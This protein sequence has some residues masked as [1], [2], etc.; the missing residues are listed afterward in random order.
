MLQAGTLDRY[1]N[2][3]VTICPVIAYLN[4]QKGVLD[5]WQRSIDRVAPLFQRRGWQAAVLC[6]GGVLFVSG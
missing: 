5:K 4:I 1:F 6:K 3:I 2:M